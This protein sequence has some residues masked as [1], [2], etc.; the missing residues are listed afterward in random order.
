[1]AEDHDPYAALRSPDYRRVLAGNVL[2]ALGS[3]MQGVAV[4]WELYQRTNSPAALGLVGLVQ[5][6][7]VLLLSL[8]AGH[9]AD[10][11]SR[12]RLF[13]A[14][15]SLMTLAS[16]GLATLSAIEGPVPLMYLALLLV[17]VGRA[18]S[19]P[20]RWSILPQVVPAGA[21]ANAITW[22]SSGWQVASMLGPAVGGGVI[23]VTGRAAGA[24][25]LA[26][27]AF[28]AC[29]G[30]VAP[31]RLR[32]VERLADPPTFASHLAGVRFVWATPLI[33][34]TITLD[35][36]AVLLG[37]ATALLPVYAKDI[38]EIGP[39]GLGW[40][41]AAPSVGALVMALALAHRPPLQHAGRALL[42]SVAGFGLATV[43]FGLSR[44]PLL[45]FVALAL[46]GA[47]DN[48]SIVVRGTLVQLLTPDAMRGRVSAVNTIFIVSSNELGEFESGM[49][50][51]WFGP[52]ASVVGG[53][54]GTLI[55]VAWVALRWP[56]VR[57]LGP[58]YAPVKEAEPA[59]QPST[60]PLGACN[61]TEAADDEATR[62]TVG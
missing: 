4:G 56:E 52:V 19:A 51:H 7:P 1:M 45:S 17:G 43:V 23:A 32:P 46:T 14:A 49:T 2:S 22:N 37:G 15:Q 27:A 5:F 34:A 59:A 18:F 61:L 20:A 10:R 48:V 55:V 25:E 31:I 62:P 35:L 44:D 57:R 9:A 16:A 30:L 54:V 6:L 40:L 8:P 38:L 21:L 53:G 36:F 33:L 29:A 60:L 12:K 50:A 3:Q 47:L 39:S 26:A 41:R 11:F 42:L 58:L 28:A 13:L 24:Y